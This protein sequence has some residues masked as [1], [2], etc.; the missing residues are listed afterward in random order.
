MESNHVLH[1][2]VGQILVQLESYDIV[3]RDGKMGPKDEPAKALAKI[4]KLLSNS[5]L[6]QKRGKNIVKY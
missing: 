1:A 4:R 2:L 6:L 5:A 3:S